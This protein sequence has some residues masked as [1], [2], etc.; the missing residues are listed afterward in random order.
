MQDDIPLRPPP[1]GAHSNFASPHT[2]VPAVIGSTAV[3]LALTLPCVVLRLLV[4]RRFMRSFW[5]DDC[6]FASHL[7]PATPSPSFS[8]FLVMRGIG[9]NI[10]IGASYFLFSNIVIVLPLPR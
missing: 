9:W 3:M 7:R 5:W 10:G 1:S 4:K 6:E 2:L 8:L